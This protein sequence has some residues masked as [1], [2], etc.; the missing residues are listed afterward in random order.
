[1]LIRPKISLSNNIFTVSGEF[2]FD[3]PINDI[4]QID[5]LQ[6]YPGVGLMRGGSGFAGIYKGSFELDGYGLGRLFI[7]KGIRPYIYVKF[8]ND[9]YVFFNLK[10]SEQTTDFYKE[11]ITKI[12]K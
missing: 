8:K 5:T 7:K 12:K 3:Y 4:V 11:L 10:S 1:M 9:D 2:G 6:A